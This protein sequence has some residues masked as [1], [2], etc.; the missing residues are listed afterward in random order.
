MLVRN[1]AVM[2]FSL[3][4]QLTANSLDCHPFWDKLSTVN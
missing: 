1:G 2:P 3:S 4:L